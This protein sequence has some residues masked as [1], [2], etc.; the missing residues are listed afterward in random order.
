M[1]G[2]LIVDYDQ[3]G[4]PGVG[5]F[6]A[7]VLPA[8]F[9]DRGYTIN[10]P[11]RRLSF[12]PSRTED[13]LL[14][15]LYAEVNEVSRDT[16]K[17]IVV[18]FLTELK[19]VL[20]DRKTITLP[21]LGRLRATRENNFFFVPD[22][23]LDIYAEGCSLKP[24][25]L[26]NHQTSS[27]TSRTAESVFA[28]VSVPEPIPQQES[29][30]QPMPDPEPTPEPEPV[31]VIELLDEVEIEAVADAAI[32]NELAEVAEPSPAASPE[33]VEE[34]AVEEP[35]VVVPDSEEPEAEAHASEEPSFEEP[36]VEDEAAMPASAEVVDVPSE[37]PVEAAVEVEAAPDPT[38]TPEPL[39]EPLSKEAG[40]VPYPEEEEKSSGWPWWGVL[41][42]VVVSLAVIALAVFIILANVNPDFIDS[43]LYTPEELRILNY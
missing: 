8:S 35:A 21:G 40:A 29:T 42:L 11:Y 15:D 26:K 6:V 28:P 34:P 43:I 25:S 4:L 30:P 31:P 24:V 38:P 22:E 19:A 12:H 32:L 23:D 18:Q 39:P 16:A 37:T 5:T 17:A 7:E 13:S 27:S 2:K 41:L 3:V 10:P 14:I 33:I 36:V 1:I 20:K 9:S